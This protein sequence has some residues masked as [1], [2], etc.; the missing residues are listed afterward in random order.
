MGD[1]RAVAL[2][3]VGTMALRYAS[4]RFERLI[5]GGRLVLAVFSLLAILVD[6]AE[7]AEPS[8]KTIVAPRN[9]W[10]AAVRMFAL[11]ITTGGLVCRT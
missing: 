5:A 10:P 2:S 6:P 7:P 3:P 9:S 4:G 11:R 8:W 1:R